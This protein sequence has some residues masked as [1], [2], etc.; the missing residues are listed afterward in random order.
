MQR[1][2]EIRKGLVLVAILLGVLVWSATVLASA[3]ESDG[4]AEG[5]GSALS[6][7]GPPGGSG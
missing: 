4:A 3:Q 7:P 2:M 5:K 6:S 1:M